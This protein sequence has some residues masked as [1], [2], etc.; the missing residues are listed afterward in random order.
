MMY[1]TLNSCE[2]CLRFSVLQNRAAS[3]LVAT[4]QAEL[5]GHLQLA[6]LTVIP[7]EL[8]S[9]CQSAKLHVSRS[10]SGL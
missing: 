10:V 9:Y 4:T 2:G 8:F 6:L 7:A 5:E 3:W 1:P